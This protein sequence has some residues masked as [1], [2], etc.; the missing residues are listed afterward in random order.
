M[1]LFHKKMVRKAGGCI[2]DDGHPINFALFTRY[3]I[4]FDSSLQNRTKPNKSRTR[5]SIEEKIWK[6]F[7]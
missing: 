1:I 3:Q 6:G 2:E 4:L 5:E 7:V